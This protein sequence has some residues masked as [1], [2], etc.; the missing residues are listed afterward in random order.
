MSYDSTADTLE[1]I[2]KVRTRIGEMQADLDRRAEFHDA[3]KLIE[4]EKS[5]YDQL[6]ANLK[7]IVYGSDQYKAVLAENRPTI[8]HHYHLND[9]HPEHYGHGI[10]G[11]TLMALSEMLADWKASS[12]RTKQGSIMGSLEHN[13]KRFNIDPQ[14]AQILKNTI[15]ELGW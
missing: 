14:L 1:H 5:G 6:G 10:A 15:I 13:I 2:G 7:D 3:S 8:E 11:M 9:H 12:E 4:P